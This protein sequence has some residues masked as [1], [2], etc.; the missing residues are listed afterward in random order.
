MTPARAAHRGFT[1]LE[2]LIATALLI[3]VVA[4][5]TLALNQ[6]LHM[7]RRLQ[8]LQD[9]NGA[10]ALIHSRLT[11]QVSSM[12]PCTALWL[13]QDASDSSVELV[14]MYGLED[15]GTSMFNTDQRWTRWHWSGASGVLRI[16]E[17]RGERNFI[18]GQSAA[19]GYWKITGNTLG[20]SNRFMLVPQ[21]VRD[22]K[23]QTTG[24]ARTAQAT[25]DTNT[26]SSGQPG[27]FGD[28]TDLLRNALP[29]LQYCISCT[30]EVVDLDG[31]TYAADGSITKVELAA[32][33]AFVDGRPYTDRGKTPSIVRLRFTLA[34]PYLLG[35]PKT[36]VKATY[37]FSASAP[38]DTRY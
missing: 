27:D 17:G 33:G 6:M 13:S 32:P 31:N 37:S 18:V 19:S 2:L 12:H 21:P 29:V 34:T 22:P 16:S 23:D 15:S 30:I 20:G 28:H 8:A 26:W 7:V 5:A 36:T 9:M 38:N 35:D 1:L 4:V 24:L 3:S 11:Q 25:L 14:F 10:A